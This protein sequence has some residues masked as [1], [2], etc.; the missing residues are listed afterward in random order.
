MKIIDHKQTGSGK[1]QITVEIEGDSSL[2][3]LEQEDQLALLLN[4]VGKLGT[5]H[6][7]LNHDQ[8][9]KVLEHDSGR[10]YLKGKKK[11]ITKVHMVV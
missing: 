5:T 7:L 6:L 1:T 11:V 4:E 10:Q 2:S 3:F 9:T 8:S